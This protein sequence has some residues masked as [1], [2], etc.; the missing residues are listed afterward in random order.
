M[1]F[2]KVKGWNLYL[3]AQLCKDIGIPLML[4]SMAREKVMVV[5]NQIKIN[6]GDNSLFR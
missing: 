5:E 3:C 6:H 1:K 2:M 4:D